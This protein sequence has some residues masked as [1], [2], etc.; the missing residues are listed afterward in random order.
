MAQPT[1]TSPVTSEFGARTTALEAVQGISLKG[2][3]AIGADVTVSL[4]DLSD[5]AT[6]RQFAADW[7]KTSKA[8]QRSQVTGCRALHRALPTPQLR[9]A[10]GQ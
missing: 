4:L 7:L 9:S 1:I 5:L 8:R 2:R 3:N 10:C 6:V